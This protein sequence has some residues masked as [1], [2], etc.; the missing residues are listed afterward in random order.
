MIRKVVF[1]LI[2]VSAAGASALAYHEISSRHPDRAAAPAPTPVPASPAP[3]KPSAGIPLDADVQ[4][5][6]AAAYGSDPQEGDEDQ[7]GTASVSETGD[8]NAN[9]DPADSQD[10]QPNRVRRVVRVLPS[11]PV[12]VVRVERPVLVAAASIEHPLA[13]PASV[14]VVHSG[15]LIPAGTPFTL[16]LAES[17][18]SKISETDQSFA[19]TLDRD[20]D[21]DGKTVIAAGTPVIG[22]VVLARP[23]GAL[24]GEAKLEL[25]VT[26]ISIKKHDLDVSTDVQGF[27]PVLQGKNKFTRFMKG[28]AKRAGG[29][30]HEVFL[31]EQ[32]AYTF[33]LA[34]P[35]H[36]N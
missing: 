13:V 28:I 17:L 29:N 18:G 12:R 34:N 22:K 36:V 15:H 6:Q 8:G 19:A 3:A 2:L 14:A 31:E 1:G 9:Q 5:N 33:T 21:I 7:G 11:S 10:L 23:A 4:D 24:A 16:R 30:E 26:S 20:I 27:G 25:A 35:L 32:T